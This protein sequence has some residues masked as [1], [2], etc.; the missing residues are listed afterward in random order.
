[1]T[2]LSKLYFGFRRVSLREGAVAM[3]TTSSTAGRETGTADRV[4]PDWIGI[5]AVRCASISSGL[6]TTRK[7]VAD[8]SASTCASASMMGP[9]RRLFSVSAVSE[10]GTSR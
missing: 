5:G 8:G 1:M 10:F 7:A 9:R 3:S 4:A 6:T 2:K